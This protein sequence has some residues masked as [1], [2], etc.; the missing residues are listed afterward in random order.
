MNSEN[1]NEEEKW[2]MWDKKRIFVRELSG[3][4]AE[5]YKKLLEQPRVYKSKQMPF[6]GGPLLFY[7]HMINPKSTEI[8]QSI[9]SH[10]DVLAP[11][12]Y[13]QKHGHMNS[14]LFYILDGKGYDVHEK[15]RYDWEAGDVCIVENGCVHQH[16]ND[17]SEQP[18][19]YIVFKAKPL[20]LF[21]HL[22]FQKNV[23]YPPVEPKPGWEDFKPE[24]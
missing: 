7:K 9:V 20:F 16:F 3:K 6:K 17:E 5:I 13:G 15:V 22:M 23:T 11:G 21:F 10:I 14:A 24:D 2:A 12:A 18:V 19:R 1:P 8:L 4:Y